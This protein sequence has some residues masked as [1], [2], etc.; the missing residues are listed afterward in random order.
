[1]EGLT[2]KTASARQR[3][4]K[5]LAEGT[6]QAKA[7]G[8]VLEE[9]PGDQCRWRVGAEVGVWGVKGGQGPQRAGRK[10][11]SVHVSTS[12]PM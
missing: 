3:S 8:Y 5:C 1:M 2:E 6:A 9:E 11:G 10:T 12:L 4:S 7:L